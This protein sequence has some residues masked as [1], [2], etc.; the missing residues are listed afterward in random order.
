MSRNARVGVLVVIVFA[1]GVLVG[2][3]DVGGRAERGLASA[4]RTVEALTASPREAPR[5]A[6]PSQRADTPDGLA[7]WAVDD[8]GLMPIFVKRTQ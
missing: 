3:V 8:S 4:R 2:Q 1:L 6:G 7:V 5:P